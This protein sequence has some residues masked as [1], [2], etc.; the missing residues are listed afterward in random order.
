MSRKDNLVKSKSI[1]TLRA[2]HM[3]VPSGSIFENDYVTIIKD[4]GIFN[5]EIPL[6]SDSNFK[7]RIGGSNNGKKKHSRGGFT[8]VDNGNGNVWTLENL[9]DVKKSTDG[10]IALKCNYSSIKDFA[11]FGSAVELIKAT[12]NDIVLRFPGGIYYYQTNI[13]PK[14]TIGS[15]TYYMVSNEFNIDFWSPK[16]CNTDETDNPLRILGANYMNY[17]YGNGQEVNDFTVSIT[18]D[19]RDSIIGT[20][21]FGSQSPNFSIYLDGDGNKYLL[22]RNNGTGIIIQPKPEFFDE[23]WSSI[24]DFEKVLLNRN[25]KPLYRAVLERPYISEGKHYYE[26]KTF[27]WPTIV[28]GV[29]DVSSGVFGGY[30]NS[31]MEVAEY[32]DEYDSDNIWRMM[33]H[34]SIKNLDY[35]FKKTSNGEEVDLSDIDFSRMRAM[36]RIYGRLFDDIKRYAD[37]IKYINSITYDEK[38]NLPD[39][40]LSDVVELGG[41]EAKSI[42]KLQ[43]TNHN[44]EIFSDDCFSGVAETSVYEINGEFMKRLALSK[45]YIMSE[46]G[47]RRG[48]QSILG[49][50]GYRYVDDGNLTKIGDYTIKEHIRV[51]YQFPNYSNTARLR[52][53][54][55]ENLYGGENINIMEGYPVAVIAPARENVTD[56]DWYLVPWV[57]NGK[58]YVDNIYFQE[59]GGWGRIH[60]KEINLNIT[61]ATVIHDRYS[62]FCLDLYSETATYMMYVNDIDEL[63]SLSNN[64]IYQGMICYVTDITKVYTTYSAESDYNSSVI[65]PVPSQPEEEQSNEIVFGATSSNNV[66]TASTQTQQRDYSHYF[67]LYNPA[68]STHIGFVNN[69]L[70]SCYGWKNI[71][72]SEFNGVNPT[73]LDGLKVLY[74]ESLNLDVK[75]N[76]P[77]CGYGN[78]DNGDSYIEKLNRLF[79]TE[80]EEG[81]FD[82]IKDDPNFTNDYNMIRT[83]GFSVGDLIIDNS[84]CYYFYD[85]EQNGNETE[86]VFKASEE[87]DG[88]HGSNQTDSIDASYSSFVNAEDPKSGLKNTE[89]AAF[90]VINV[91]N[92]IIEIK[93][94]GNAHFEKY[95]SDV[96]F[97]YLNELIP[98]TAILWYEFIGGT[99]SQTPSAYDGA[100]G[101]NEITNEIVADGVIIDNESTYFI[102]NND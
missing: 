91:K 64:I 8:Q 57:D 98:S 17:V 66:V 10:E 74:L 51:A 55:G 5:D 58:K 40:F 101:H 25:S 78:Y 15:T 76:N 86:I 70:Y 37:G 48:I 67:I 22:T 69:D 29:P 1:Y 96:V 60:N 59:K 54:T 43:K 44:Q 34:E 88:G 21:K 9:P 4:D 7:F 79:G 12:V 23:F 83:V 38:D 68:L 24:D 100:S 6:F 27:I 80:L 13:A 89:A 47:T 30:L 26:Y 65:V 18:G 19:C 73:T 33:T 11:Y 50:F 36:L 39:Y 92:L 53:Y 3:T 56:D 82:Y 93:T 49:M 41:Y 97:K 94:N 31:L 102:E 90:S 87:V 32:Y 77:H 45:D 95:L 75:G 81:H 61:S 46:K 52:T 16:G 14:I 35:T 28:P 63:T 71:L 85:N 84:K 99:N 2:K 62:N 72:N 20:V 42:N